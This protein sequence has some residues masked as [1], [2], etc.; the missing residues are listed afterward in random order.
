RSGTFAL[1]LLATLLFAAGP[2]HAVSGFEDPEALNTNAASDSGDDSGPQVTTDGL[3]HWV[4]VWHSYDTLGGTIGADA[5]ILVSRSVDNGAT[6]TPPAALNTNASSDSGDDFEP[7]VTTDRL[8]RWVAVWW[9]NDSLGGAIGTDKDILVSRSTN[10]GATWTAPSP[11][12]T[13]AALD[14]RGDYNPQ[15]TTNGL[16]NWVAAWSSEDSLGGTIGLDFD[17]LVSRST[18]NG[19]AWTAPAP[20][21][22]NAAPDSEFDANP[23]VTTDGLGRWVAVWHSTNTL[24]GPFTTD[25]DVLVS[26]STN[27][28]AT[29]TA[30]AAL[31]TNAASDN[32]DD[33]FP[34]VTTDGSGKWVAVWISTN[35]LGGTIGTDEDILVSRSTNFGATW[36][37]PAPLNTNAATDSGSDV[38]PQVTTD[39]AGNW[40]AAWTSDDTLG[41][42]IGADGDALISR[43]TNNGL[44]WTAPAALNTNAAFDSGLDLQ[45]QLTTDGA[46]NWVAV[47]HSDDTLGGT[48]G[49]DYDI[50]FAVSNDVGPP[51]VVSVLRANPSPTNSA[52]VGFTVTFSEDVTGVGIGDFT[53]TVFGV[54][55]ASIASISADTGSVRTVTVNTGSGSGTIWLNVSDDDSIT[56]ADG[57]KLGNTGA[58]NG[59]FNAGE[60]YSIDKAPPTISVGAPSAGLTTTGPVTYTVTY[61]GATAVTLANAAVTLI[62]TGTASG[63]L[64]VSGAGTAART[65]TISG[66]TGDGTLRISIAPGTASD[67]AGNPAPSAGP[68]A[69]FTVDNAQPGITLSSAAPD[70]TNAAIPV[71]VALSE[72]S[73]DFHLSDVSVTNGAAGGFAGS[74]T[75]YS[76]TITPAGLGLVTAQVAAG[77]FS[78]ALGNVNTASNVL[79]RTYNNTSPAIILTSAAQEST[80]SAISVTATLSAASTDFDATDVTPTNAS[81]SAFAGGGA[82]YTFT[83]TPSANGVFS[84]LVNAG[85]F[86]DAVTNLNTASNVL[87]RIYDAVAPTIVLSSAAPDPVNTAIVV[88]ATLSESSADFDAGDITPTNAAVSGVAGG[89]ASY[90]FTLTPSAQGVFSAQVSA[91]QFTDAATNPNTASNTLGRT[92]INTSPA[93]T[94][95]TT[96]SD[97]VNA[98]ISVTA[99]LSAAST[100]FDADD[101]TPTNALVSAFTGLGASYSFTLAPLSQGVFSALV[102]AGVC[103]D[104][105]TNANTASNLLSRTFDFVGPLVTVDP[106]TTSNN[107]PPLSGTVDDPAAAVSVTVN[108]QTAPATNNGDGTWTLAGN[109][110]AALEDGTYNVSVTA[111]D[112]A[113]NIGFEFTSNELT[114][115]LNITVMPPGLK[116]EGDIVELTAPIGSG[117]QWQKDNTNIADDP[118][119]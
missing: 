28:G 98:P 61:T 76:F 73:T 27:N 62:S 31:N 32:G 59:N 17:I 18:N 33:Y 115:I 93:I 63:A 29:W 96:A 94:L 5:D 104:A 95:T 19:V 3:G 89:G 67:V 82:S 51:R 11:L 100:D 7:Q 25:L 38:Y 60:V 99:A 103:T 24:G 117:Y 87:S 48:I 88:T 40:V 118:P 84:A 44:T 52:S 6:W 53:L 57:D 58:N 101:I 65:V 14:S 68:S 112:P 42:S 102:D 90:T 81:V 20:L 75:T 13:N 83:L 71:T 74:G 66:I 34:Q 47:W 2:A 9:T 113:T 92:Y 110:L 15:V 108:S 41:G 72:P 12:N 119:R 70:P 116:R 85:M 4:A 1:L 114:I 22:T 37:A 54:S 10:N 55:G 106:L 56:D 35:T 111:T 39:A 46:G 23:Q 64:N 69:I 91:A 77:K 86:T 49:A 30:P 79:S 36:T 97:P 21:N 78:D 80:N 26:R 105:A 50:L 8:G 43:S 45:P 107:R 109:T 16:G